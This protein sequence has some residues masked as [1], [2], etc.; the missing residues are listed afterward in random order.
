MVLKSYVVLFF[1]QVYHALTKGLA[2]G[3]TGRN[4]RL[5][6][7]RYCVRKIRLQE[8]YDRQSVVYDRTFFSSLL[9]EA[10]SDDTQ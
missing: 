7:Q 2:D 6:Y 8:D 9:L 10:S 3:F 4:H 5:V 1:D